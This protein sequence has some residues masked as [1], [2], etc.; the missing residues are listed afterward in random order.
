MDDV[1]SPHYRY[2]NHSKV[3][4]CAYV[5]TLVLRTDFSLSY[6]LLGIRTVFRF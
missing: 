2:M 6:G 4:Y 3:Q 1:E 5:R